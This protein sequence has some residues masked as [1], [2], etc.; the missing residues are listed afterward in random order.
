VSDFFVVKKKLN[1]KGFSLMELMIAVAIVGIL[2]AIGI[3]QYVRFQ[4]KARP[5]EAKAHLTAIYS[6]EASFQAEWSGYS[7]N[8][9]GIGYA[10][11]G[12]NLKYTAGFAA[13]ACTTTGCSAG[14]PAE[15]AA[16][17][18]I[19]LATVNVGSLAATF[20]PLLTP[21]TAIGMSAIVC[22]AT[23]FTAWAVG[24]PKNVPTSALADQWS[25]DQ[26]KLVSN[27]VPGT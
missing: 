16:N 18:Q 9:A 14:A 4:A 12:S 17:T 26:T 23:T 15:A 19:H 24:D 7:S 1:N 6:A 22:T 11:S 5:G 21:A 2:A 8:M 3:P 25:I 13:T 20:I 10:A 27:P